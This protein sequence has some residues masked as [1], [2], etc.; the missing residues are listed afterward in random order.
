MFIRLCM[1]YLPY[2]SKTSILLHFCS[3]CSTLII[4]TC[5][6]LISFVLHNEYQSWR[7]GAFQLQKSLQFVQGYFHTKEKEEEDNTEYI[8]I[9]YF[10]RCSSLTKMPYMMLALVS[11]YFF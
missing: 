5:A 2:Y 10:S 7:G 8:V 6:T 3:T 1:Y 4:L 9:P 11:V